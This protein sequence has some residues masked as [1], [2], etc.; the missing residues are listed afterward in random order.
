MSRRARIATIGL[1]VL[2]LGGGA[3]V[4]AFAAF[5]LFSGHDGV[6]IDTAKQVG[7]CSKGTAPWQ[8]Q[9]TVN[10]KNASSHARRLSGA[11]LYVTYTLPGKAVGL[12]KH[13]QVVSS[14]GF[15]RGAIVAGGATARFHP[16]VKV[17]LPCNVDTA[18]LGAGYR[19]GQVRSHSK[20]GFKGANAPLPVGTVGVVG[21]TA[22]LGLVLAM[23]QLRRRG[24]HQLTRS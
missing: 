14:G 19:F 1:V 21:L 18:S 17:S 3:F 12:A 15:S 7:A 6:H 20:A 9:A 8:V 10:V 13:V 5:G 2:V 4:T 11:Q 22:I 16:V 23:S 24:T